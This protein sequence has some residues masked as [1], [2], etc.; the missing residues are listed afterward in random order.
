[1]NPVI[2]VVITGG[3]VDP[4]QALCVGVGVLVGV[5]VGLPLIRR[6]MR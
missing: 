1:M 5:W 6:W 2:P 4:V 3:P